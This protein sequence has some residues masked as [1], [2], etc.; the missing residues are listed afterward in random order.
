MV[1]TVTWSMGRANGK[2]GLAAVLALCHLVG[3]EAQPRGEVYAAANDRFQSGRLF[4]EIAAI[5]ERT[6]W[7]A[8]RVSIRRHVKELE[9]I[10]G[11]GSLFAALSADVPTKHGLAP[12][13]VVMD[14]LGQSQSRELLDTLQTALGKKPDPMLWIISTQAATDAMPMSEIVDYGLQVQRGDIIDPSFHLV[15]Y[16]APP[17]ADPWKVATWR[18]ANPGLGDILSLD[19]VK[20]LAKQ[21]KNV[22][23]AEASFRNH[24]LNQRVATSN[25]F[26]APSVWKACGSAVDLEALAGGVDVYGGLDLSA[27]RDLTALVLIGKVDGKW[28]VVPTF[29]LPSEGLVE[30]SR[31]DRVPYDLW[32]RQ[33]FLKTT[34]GKAISSTLRSISAARSIATTFASSLSTAGTCVT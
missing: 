22:P 11:T 3:P 32:A 18:K 24:V 23:S 10:G 15:L 9:D 21:A 2:T 5:V 31:A 20:R 27:V 28:H 33:G 4:N 16:A 30:K 1:R 25:V 12:N 8:R 13:F 14:E 19:H 34:P 26:I 7:L 6:P 17:E 29:W